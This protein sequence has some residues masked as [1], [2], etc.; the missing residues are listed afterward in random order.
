MRK[1]LL[2]SGLVL[3]G[4]AI[5][6][7]VLPRTFRT[8]II[9]GSGVMMANALAWLFIAPLILA[10]PALGIGLHSAL[11]QFM[12]E[13]HEKRPVKTTLSYK[14]KN[15]KSEDIRERFERLKQKHPSLDASF[16]K[17][18]KQIDSIKKRQA[19]LQEMIE[20]NDAEFLSDAPSALQDAEQLIIRNLVWVINRGIVVV[21]DDSD[22]KDDRDFEELIEKVLEA[23]EQVIEKCRE[24]LKGASDLI[25]GKGSSG[26]TMSIEAWISAIRQQVKSSIFEE[27]KK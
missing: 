24:L 2:V 25:S 4:L 16:D 22:E 1:K 13:R 18:T 21:T 6:T 19:N 12:L 11:K 27:G 17:C 8:S 23:N 9:V 10:V 7:F 5:L 15:L 20:L 14:S 3:L 26:S